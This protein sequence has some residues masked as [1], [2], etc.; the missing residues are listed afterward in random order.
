[1][2]FLFGS[3]IVSVALLAKSV[4]KQITTVPSTSI[5]SVNAAPTSSSLTPSPGMKAVADM[6]KLMYGSERGPLMSADGCQS[7]GGQWGSY[8]L[9]APF[10]WPTS[11]GKKN[12][13]N[14]DNFVVSV[15]KLMTQ[16]QSNEVKADNTYKG[17]LVSLSGQVHEVRKDF[18]GSMIISFVPWK[19]KEDFVIHSTMCYPDGQVDLV[20]SLLK[21]DLVNFFGK[22]DG[23]VVDDVIIKDCKIVGIYRTGKWAYDSTGAQDIDGGR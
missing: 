16:Y 17:R 12:D 14:N 15:Q 20:S 5:S 13:G 23:F 7:A 22:V 18:T 9:A 2:I 19:D 10:C 8:G 11:F 6:Y 3:C 4:P 21:G 1:M